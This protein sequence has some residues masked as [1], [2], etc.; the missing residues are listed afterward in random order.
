ML[1]HTIR[2]NKTFPDVFP[3]V[4]FKFFF[5]Q[6]TEMRSVRAIERQWLMIS[7]SKGILYSDWLHC[8]LHNKMKNSVFLRNVECIL[9]ECIADSWRTIKTNSRWLSYGNDFA[10]IYVR[11]IPP[12]NVSADDDLTKQRFHNLSMRERISTMF[13]WKF[14]NRFR[15][16]EHQT[17]MEFIFIKLFML[18][19]L[20]KMKDF[21]SS[22]RKY[23][24][25]FSSLKKFCTVELLWDFKWN[26]IFYIVLTLNGLHYG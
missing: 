3:I 25:K 16:L 14:W 6:W 24:N 8:N 17:V 12:L 9:A 18:G 2:A 7:I 22:G 11:F 5:L 10:T 4:V 15:S 13:V 1:K 21:E 19:I 26:I 23:L 20:R